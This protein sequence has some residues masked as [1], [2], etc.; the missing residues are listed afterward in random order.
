[1]LA[2]LNPGHLVVRRATD[3]F[4]KA[5]HCPQAGLSDLYAGSRI[6]GRQ[7]A[8]QANLTATVQSIPL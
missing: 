5:R 7:R 4:G 8:Q 2:D 3:E 1:V 6:A